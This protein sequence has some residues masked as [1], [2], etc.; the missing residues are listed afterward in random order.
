M[1][2]PAGIFDGQGGPNIGVLQFLGD[3]LV[4][5]QIANAMVALTYKLDKD[6]YVSAAGVEFPVPFDCTVLDVIV[7]CEIASSGGTVTLSNHSKAVTNAIVMAVDQVV[8]RAGSIDQVTASFLKD[9]D[10]F[11]FVTNAAADRGIVRLIVLKNN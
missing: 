6:C 11:E 4:P 5:D 2:K 7:Q 1:T 9:T 3:N 10:N 8:T